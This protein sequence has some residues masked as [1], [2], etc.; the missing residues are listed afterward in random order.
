MQI[1]NNSGATLNGVSITDTWT[2][3]DYDG[4][5]Q[6]FG[7]ASVTA[8]TLV[9]AP[10]RYMR[11]DLSPL[12]PGATGQIQMGMYITRALQPD[13]RY[14]P[15]VLGNSAYITTS[16][17]GRTANSDNANTIV[18]GPV[19]QLIPNIVPPQPVDGTRAGR[20]ITFTYTL[21]NKARSDAIDATNVVISQVMPAHTE[22]Y[23]ASPA[24]LSVYSPTNNTA[25]WQ[26]P[27]LQVGAITTVT[28]TARI[29]P[30]APAGFIGN[31]WLSCGALA[32]ALVNVVACSQD[33]SFVIDDVFEKRSF[34]ETPPVQSFPVSSTFNS[35][36][37]TYTVFVYN[38]FTHTASLRVTD[39]LPTYNG[40]TSRAFQYLVPITGV[41]PPTFV[42][43]TANSAVWDTPPIAGW[44]VY[45]FTFHVWVPANMPID[46]N[47]VRR[48][49]VNTLSGSYGS[50]ALPRN[51]GY[52]DFGMRVFVEA[53]VLIDK[54]VT[55]TTQLNGLPVTYTLSLSNTGP[56][57]VS[58]VRVTETLPNNV[59]N[60]NFQ[61]GG[62]VS[63]TAPVVAGGD[64]AIWDGI[65]IPPHSAWSVV[66]TATVFGRL[67]VYCGNVIYASSSDTFIPA[68]IGIAPVYIDSSFR[69][70]KQALQPSVVLGGS[71]T[72][73]VSEFNIGGVA[74][75]MNGFTDTLPAGFYYGTS[76]VYTDH[77]GAPFTLLPNHQNT[78]SSTFAVNVVSTTI[79]CDALPFYVPQDV[80]TFGMRITSPVDM[81]G[82]WYN[83]SPAASVLIL[84]QV[85]LVK[86]ASR[87]DLIPGDVTTFT[88]T[89]NNNTA[90][91]ISGVR[92][93]DTLPTLPVNWTFV[94]VL[95]GTSAPVI[96]T[97]V[98]VWDNQTIPANGALVLKFIAMA[99][100]S[101]VVATVP[102]W[103]YLKA[104]VPA[105]PLICMPQ[106]SK[107]LEIHPPVITVN[108]IAGP[109]YPYPP[110]QAQVP[111][112]GKFYYQVSFHNNTPYSVTIQRFTETLPGLTS[113]WRFD[114]MISPA[115]AQP[116]ST[117]PLVWQ[118][119]VVPRFQDYILS[120]Y[121]RAS[122]DF[123]T[124][125][126]TWSNSA[127]AVG[128][129]VMTGLV[130][131]GFIL[132]AVMG[133][134]EAPVQVI[135]GVGLD[136][137]VSPDTLFSG[138][139]AIYTI[140]LVNLSGGTINNVRI[141]DTL[142]AG[143][144]YGSMVVGSSPVLTTPLVWDVGNVLNG[145][146][147]RVTISFRATV[148]ISTATG[149]YYNRVTATSSNVLIP[150]TDDTAPLRVVSS[151]GPQPDL[152]V[153]KSDG[154]P[155]ALVG[156][157]VTYTIN[158]TNVGALDA[159]G[160]VLTETLPANTV[161]V[162]PSEWQPSAVAGV[163]T[164]IMPDLPPTQ[165]AA[166]TIAL[167]IAG[168][169]PSGFYTNSVSIRATNERI[170][171]N[172][173]AIDVDL[174]RVLDLQ[175]SKSDG[176][177]EVSAGQ[178]I[179]YL[180]NYT[181]AGNDVVTNVVMTDT[182]GPGLT[183]IGRTWY[184]AGGGVFTYSVG[185]LAAGAS[186]V[187]PFAAQV[188]SGAIGGAWVSNTVVIGFDGHD[189]HPA[190]N[191]ATDIDVVS[192]ANLRVTLDDGVGVV[193]PGQM[194]TYSFG[195]GNN[196]GATAGTSVLTATLPPSL[197]LLSAPGWTVDSSGY[198]L[199]LGDLGP[200]VTGT[201]AIVVQ[202]PVTLSTGTRLT[203]TVIVTG[204]GDVTPADNFARD[205]DM[206]QTTGPDLQISGATA[207]PAV[208][209]FPVTIILTVTNAG[210]GVAADWFWVDLYINRMPTS[211]ADLGDDAKTAAPTAA[212]RRIM[213]PA[214]LSPGQS[215]TVVYQFTP[216][217]EGT[218]ALYAQVD[219][220]DLS[221][222]GPGANC[223]DPSYS[224]ILE[225]NEANNVYGPLAVVAQTPFRQYLP[226]LRR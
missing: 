197:A 81:A 124:Y 58:N 213:A 71:L 64:T 226:I 65:S 130:P 205:I 49:Y 199:A 202:V 10:L 30:T 148:G 21:E 13:Y 72:Y 28:L 209:G 87:I 5:Y 35:R 115:D 153:S 102:A 165:T 155:T 42:T 90:N 203:A 159:T 157:G 128:T 145:D 131:S 75:V 43:Y 180:I 33:T 183:R 214:N 76:P 119:L 129:G 41:N 152:E 111:P 27:L 225:L 83:A 194:I 61:W 51:D 95:A 17:P 210:T 63:G 82:F 36:V 179:T 167:Q 175:V 68:R 139:Q 158:Y 112:L 94:G 19:L 162:G 44:D 143:F 104:S 221:S 103:N 62:I 37:L 66:F 215:T 70:D 211:R 160:I 18:A 108:K 39:T 59:P 23:S 138:D 174:M 54:I 173:T 151:L 132:T 116:V 25:Y 224:R 57:P 117:S 114:S 147:N 136:K 9:T 74:A 142:P 140:T 34:A 207:G 69:Y 181:N 149:T 86:D 55:P 7:S 56:T 40:D 170:T 171:N 89:L 78:Y 191:A 6:T 20:V 96:T 38:P 67:Y 200:G 97:P 127:P 134:L 204:V 176:A 16:T 98:I 164:R 100:P 198:V 146:A 73:Y 14:P 84:P 120:F 135:P 223:Y 12:A 85:T 101:Q 196:G 156:D 177:N 161:L 11:F 133:Y 92:I 15:T 26:L 219:T 178:L 212:P 105:N 4:A 144:Q 88:L 182:L 189:S 192:Y 110:I 154:Q 3:Q 8:A 93:T 32:D 150:P 169:A 201:A 77:V 45:S 109:S 193:L 222:V 187:V 2:L 31:P 1:T 48:E 184:P 46:P 137:V 206:V 190:D 125:V 195:Y 185:A 52:H 47:Q 123:G 24:S 79:P 50:L 172:N 141:T 60:C 29:H 208:A 106:T 126:N 218:Y 216:P 163:Y 186:G 166:V 122:T 217:S 121:V 168:P 80:A 188:D 107:Y 220:C 91:A 53:Q 99:P 118:N 22:F 113:K